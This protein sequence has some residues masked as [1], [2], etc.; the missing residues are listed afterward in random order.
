VNKEHSL[1][2]SNYKKRLFQYIDQ[3]TYEIGIV[4]QFAFNSKL[5]RMS[6]ITRQLGGKCFDL[7]VKGA[8]EM[9]ASLSEPETG[10]S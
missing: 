4:R 8:P 10:T 6:V 9:I 3:A 1:K 2:V 5:Q 7:Y